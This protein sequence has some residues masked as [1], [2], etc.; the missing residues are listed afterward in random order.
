LQAHN[1]IISTII[2]FKS[3]IW[4]SSS[5]PRASR[6]N[7]S[8][9]T[10]LFYYYILCF[11][12]FYSIYYGHRERFYPVLPYFCGMWHAFHLPHDRKAQ[13]ILYGLSFTDFII[14]AYAYTFRVNNTS[15][16]AQEMPPDIPQIKKRDSLP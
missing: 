12:V 13:F 15:H 11:G 9:G 14:I 16:S 2:P 3:S 10:L 1:F 5:A 8:N 4:Q 7:L 6:L